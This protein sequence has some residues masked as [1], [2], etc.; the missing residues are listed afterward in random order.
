MA[1]AIKNLGP[2]LSI[3]LV[4]CTQRRRRK[5]EELPDFRHL[6]IDVLD[7]R[8][9]K[10]ASPGLGASRSSC[11]S[12]PM[13]A[14]SR[15]PTT[16]ETSARRV[17]ARGSTIR[18]SM[19]EI[20]VFVLTV[21]GHSFCSALVC[22]LRHTHARHHTHRVG[23]SNTNPRASSSNAV[24]S[25][26]N[27]S[28]TS[29]PTAPQPCSPIYSSWRAP[30]RSDSCCVAL[31][32]A[33]R[34]QSPPASSSL[35]AHESLETSLSRAHI[36]ASHA[37][38]RVVVASP[39]STLGLGSMTANEVTGARGFRRVSFAAFAPRADGVVIHQSIET[40]TLAR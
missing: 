25:R 11:S 24:A 13:M 26:S 30:A 3:P 18:R 20:A 34:R 12:T 39:W 33:P 28:I 15:A 36:F 4:G 6:D 31:V 32:R 38:A 16:F 22:S 37:C 8:A 19:G 14:S 5:V 17:R 29:V 7:E 1:L 10:N 9:N 23:R 27:A 2:V 21:R 35:L 40:R